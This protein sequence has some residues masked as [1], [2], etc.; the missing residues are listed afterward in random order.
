[1]RDTP[2]STTHEYSNALQVRIRHHLQLHRDMSPHRH[3]L[4]ILLTAA[5]AVLFSAL[6]LH[7]QGGAQPE[8][9][10]EVVAATA[11]PT[12]PPRQSWTSPRRAFTVG[13]VVTVLID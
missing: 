12:R 2:D 9:S 11:S 8:P 3:D 5:V 13:D 4:A 1:K 7:A 10:G 6:P